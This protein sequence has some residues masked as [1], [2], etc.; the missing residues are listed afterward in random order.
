MAIP[1]VSMRTIVDLISLRERVAV[2]TGG[3]RG[4]GAAV[5]QRF[6]EA[7]AHLAIAD[8]DKAEVEQT[9]SRLSET[10][11]CRCIGV[12]V[13]VRDANALSD[14]AD[15]AVRELGGLHIWV[16]NAGIYPITPLLE[17]SEAQWDHVL[18]VNLK[19]TFLGAREAARRMVAA[20]DAGVIINLASVAAYRASSIGG[21]EYV[22]AKHGVR[23]LTKALA[24][25]LGQFG[26]RVL[27][28]APATIET[29]GL[30]ASREEVRA[31]GV[32]QVD[33]HN[34]RPLGRDGVPDDVAR[35]ALFCASDLSLLMTGSTLLLDGGTLS[36]G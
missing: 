16:N 32:E 25:Q 3:A 4:I 22:S 31:L 30:E 10:Y 35:V 13:D 19:G 26:I 7:G 34:E 11:G 15:R 29:P 18:D 1:D 2:V 14:L 33:A 27:A 5:A 9:A 23:G 20:G 24:A 12:E 21:T 28:L 8:L 17:L 6:A 36:L